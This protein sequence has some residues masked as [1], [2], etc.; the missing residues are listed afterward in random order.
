MTICRN[1]SRTDVSGL[2]SQGAFPSAGI[3]YADAAPST[4]RTAPVTYP[5]RSLARYR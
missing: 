4:E 2:L 3:F 5:A 1:F